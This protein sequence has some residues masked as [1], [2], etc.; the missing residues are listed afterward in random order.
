MLLDLPPEIRNLIYRHTLFQDPIS[1]SRFDRTPLPPLLFTNRQIYQEAILLYY[2]LNTFSITVPLS[3]PYR[4][5]G[6]LCVWLA[7]RKMKR[8][9]AILGRLRI[10]VDLEDLCFVRDPRTGGVMDIFH[11]RGHEVVYDS[12][13]GEEFLFGPALRQTLGGIEWSEERDLLEVVSVLVN[14]VG[15]GEREVEEDWQMWA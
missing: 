11:Q 1:I 2:N 9:L 12:D 14:G 5:L 4:Q 15:G 7:W 6:S 10:N 13:W 3:E 8:Q